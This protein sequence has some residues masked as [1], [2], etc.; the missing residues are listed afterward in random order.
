MSRKAI[1]ILVIVV[2]VIIIGVVGFLIYKKNK[3]RKDA[4]AA[5]QLAMLQAQLKCKCS[6]NTG[7]ALWF[8]IK[9]WI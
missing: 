4:E 2:I 8:S 9:N 1:I 5:N 3:D 6:W 7:C